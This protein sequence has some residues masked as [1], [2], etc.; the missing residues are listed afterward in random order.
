MCSPC[1]PRDTQESFFSNI[2]IQKH[3]FF[4]AQPSLWSNFH[5]CIWLLEQYQGQNK[6]RTGW[7]NPGC[8]ISILAQRCRKKDKAMMVT[9]IWTY[10]QTQINTYTIID[11]LMHT[12]G[13]P[14]G[15]DG[16]E[17]ACNAGYPGS[18]PGGRSFGVGNGNPLQYS[19]WRIPWTEEPGRL[20]SI[21]QR[22]KYDWVTNTGCTPRIHKHMHAHTHSVLSA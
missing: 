7:N 11:T 3:Q 17:S 8:T 12:K 16:K 21:G 18:I 1:S 5:I 9:F 14:G 10:K 2:T 4:G 15:S 13:F 22:I 20:Q 19:C 6:L